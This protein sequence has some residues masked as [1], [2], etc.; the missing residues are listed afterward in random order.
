MERGQ[1]LIFICCQYCISAWWC[2]PRKQFLNI[3]RQA[4]VC[5]IRSGGLL[6][7]HLVRSRSSADVTWAWVGGSSSL[8]MWKYS[9]GRSWLG[10][11]ISCQSIVKLLSLTGLKCACHFLGGRGGGRLGSNM[12][13]F[14]SLSI[15]IQSHS[16]TQVSLC[17]TIRQKKWTFSPKLVWR[18]HL[19]EKA[20]YV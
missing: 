14:S 12:L 4:S 1:V 2:A 10:A 16:E 18:T 13:F 3:L 19:V 11:R 17:W 9:N 15:W 8:F 5:F 6:S 7:A 20:Y